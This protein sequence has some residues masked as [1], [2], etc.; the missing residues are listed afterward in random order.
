MVSKVISKKRLSKPWIN[1]HVKKLIDK[2]SK[3]FSLYN[4]GYISSKFNNIVKNDI[5]KEVEKVKCSYFSN[6]FVN[7]NNAKK[8][9]DVIRNLSG[10]KTHRLHPT[11]IL[12]N[13]ET[14]S[15][16]Q[17]ISESFVDYFSKIASK[18]N[19]DLPISQSDPCRFIERNV[20]TFFLF[21]VT[22]NECSKIV[23]NL[24]I[25]K[26]HLDTIPVKTFKSISIYIIDPLT[27][28]INSSFSSGIFPDIFKIARITPIF[29]K[30]NRN[31]R[32][33]YRPIS[34]LPFISKIF[35]RLMTNRIVNFFNKFKLFSTNQHGFLKGKS[36]FDAINQLINSIY[37]SFN[38][39]CYH[40]SVFVDLSKAFDTV[41]HSI[42]IRKLENMVLGVFL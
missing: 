7:S 18:L 24:K 9:W 5:R 32:D 31:I 13:D 38:E 30:G 17:Q 25:V 8:S 16:S 34:S 28:L 35:E 33:N 15:N 22:S 29:K 11:K 37:D 12:V 42:L 41:S 14:I 1:S 6:L 20:K 10:I 40:A 19:E 26:T 27:K 23:S 2:K 4:K 3:Y 36:T 39:K 21:P